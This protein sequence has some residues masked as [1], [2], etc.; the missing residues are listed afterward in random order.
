[1]IGINS[2]LGPI[3]ALQLQV[4]ARSDPSN[5]DWD[6]MRARDASSDNG[7]VAIELDLTVPRSLPDIPPKAHHMD[8]LSQM[9]AILEATSEQETTSDLS[10]DSARLQALQIR[11]QLELQPHG[12][13]NRASQLALALFR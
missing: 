2:S 10:T 8:F 9:E 6:G 11:Q 13:A 3:P 4:A 1:M 12:I 5:Q 7:H